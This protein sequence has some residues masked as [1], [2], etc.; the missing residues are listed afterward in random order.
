MWAG[1]KRLG[2]FL[3]LGVSCV[4]PSNHRLAVTP[5]A[6]PQITI[7]QPGG[8][9]AVAARPMPAWGNGKVG[10]FGFG[11]FLGSAYAVGNYLALITY[12]VSGTHMVATRLFSVIEGGNAAGAYTSLAW[13]DRPEAQYL[14]GNLENGTLQYNSQPNI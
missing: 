5:D 13:Y 11:E 4:S 9:V 6:A 14:V 12:A 3:T 2:E 1:R 10:Q 8:A 7:L